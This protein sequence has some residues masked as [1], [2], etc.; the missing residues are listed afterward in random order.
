MKIFLILPL[1]M[2]R[3]PAIAQQGFAGHYQDHFGNEIKLNL[4]SSFHYLWSFDLV[5]S[6]TNGTYMVSHD[7]VYL[8]IIPVYD[9]VQVSHG[10]QLVDSLVL[11]AEGRPKRTSLSERTAFCCVSQNSRPSPKVLYYRKSRLYE[12]DKQGKLIRKKRRAWNK[13]KFVPWYF[14]S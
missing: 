1:I 2:L 4:D 10:D 8:T 6:W 12:I 13:K 3:L 14:R 7:T 9:T 11:S 5:A